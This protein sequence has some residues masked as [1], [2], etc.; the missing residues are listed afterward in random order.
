MTNVN[1]INEQATEAVLDR[2]ID[3]QIKD[4][5]MVRTLQK[6]QLNQ[7]LTGNDYRRLSLSLIHSLQRMDDKAKQVHELENPS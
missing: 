1:S 3:E 6:L 2:M 7:R 5:G 4:G